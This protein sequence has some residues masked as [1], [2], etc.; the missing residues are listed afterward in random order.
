MHQE[1][2]LPRNGKEGFLYGTIISTLTVLFMTTY[3]IIYFTGE[4]NGDIAITILKTLPI[5]WII[6][7]L[8]EPTIFGRIAEALTA[9][10]TQPT[11]SFNS[12]I[13]FRILFTVLGMSAAMTLIADVVINGLHSELFSN[14]LLN[15]PRNFIIVLFAE[16]LVI[17]PIARF[18]MVKMHETQDK[19]DTANAKVQS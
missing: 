3:S 6:V 10:F 5:I 9:K 13:L 17:Q 4:F 14:W 19:K 1:K 18:F 8:I 7:M 15:W 11:D 16:V 12:K 2:R